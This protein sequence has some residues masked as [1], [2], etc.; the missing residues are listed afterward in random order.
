MRRNALT[1][2]LAVGVSLLAAAVVGPQPASAVT[3]ACDCNRNICSDDGFE[4]QLTDF[5][6]DTQ[7]GTS[8]WTYKICNQKLGT[9]VCSAKKCVGGTKDGFGC[10]VDG[11]CPGGTCQPANAGGSGA[12]GDTC[13]TSTDCAGACVPCAPDFDFHHV[14]IVLPGLGQCVTP[15]QAISISQVGCASCDPVLTCQI[16]DRDPA[17]PADLCAPNTG[18]KLCIGGTDAGK[19]CTANSQ[20]ASQVCQLVPCQPVP[21]PT[22]LKV[23]Q[24]FVTQGNLDA[25]ECVAVQLTIAGEQPTLGPG[26]VDEITKAGFKCVTD[27]LCGPSCG[28]GEEKKGCITRTIGFWG[29]HPHITDDFLPITVCG[30]VLS[31]TLAGVCNS[32]TEA[33]CV[34]PGQEAGRTCDKNPPYAQLVRQLAAA[35]LNLAASAANNGSCG[36]AI[37]TRIAQCERL[38]DANKSTI[39][40]SKC[41]D[42]LDAFNSSLDTVSTTPPPFDHPGPANPDQCQAANGNGLLIGKDCAVDC[43]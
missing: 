15:T 34:S 35:K 24:C 1:I 37:A 41:I 3:P 19:A 7:A 2:G 18:I 30:N 29:T 39:S 27:S 10:T 16:S 40:G 17:C 5:S 43:R 28:C 26:A 20:C 11:Q 12:P 4:K 38:C 6:V 14:D 13:T 25:G 23:A 21:S 22:P 36:S 8:T 32:A 31:T 33:L 42:D 9:K